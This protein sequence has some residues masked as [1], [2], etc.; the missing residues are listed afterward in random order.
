MFRSFVRANQRVCRRI[1]PRLPQA[2]IR[3][4]D[5]YVD[6]VA[7]RM[8]AAPGQTVVDVGG[9]KSCRFAHR[10]DPRLGTRIICV[11]VAEAEMAPNQDVD[12]KRVGD[13]MQGLPFDDGTVDLVVSRSVLEHL[14]SQEQFAD[15]AYR[16]LK[17][18]GYSIHFFPCKFAPFAVINQLLPN[19]VSKAL[20]HGIF[21]GKEGI[22][23]FPACYDK[24]YYSAYTRLLEA[25]QFQIER[26][27]ISYS[28]S[29]YFSFFLPC[30]LVSALYEMVVMALGIQ[31]LCAYMIVVARKDPATG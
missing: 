5:L 27:D 16:A 11:D 14:E 24:T 17:P 6:R 30:F 4:E 12:E 25:K 19:R 31:N 26:I 13:I 9:G 28:Q 2:R 18:G 29:G 10:R 23:G 8:N 21:E 22:L 15:A 1:A 20:L 3:F 7:E